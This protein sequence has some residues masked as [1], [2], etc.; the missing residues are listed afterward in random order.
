MKH[1][2]RIAVDRKIGVTA[3]GAHRSGGK[4]TTMMT[5]SSGDGKKD[6][7]IVKSKRGGY[8]GPP[9][10]FQPPPER[11]QIGNRMFR[12]EL[13]EARK[14]LKEETK[15]VRDKQAAVEAAH[16]AQIREKLRN[17]ERGVK[18]IKDNTWR[19]VKKRREEAKLKVELV[20]DQEEIDIGRN[21]S[22]GSAEAVA[23]GGALSVGD[24]GDS[25]RT[26]SGSVAIATGMMIDDSCSLSGADL[27]DAHTGF[28]RSNAVREPRPE[29]EQGAVR[30]DS[31]LFGQV[32]ELWGFVNTF[33]EPLNLRSVPS[34]QAMMTALRVL[35]PCHKALTHRTRNALHSHFYV[36]SGRV[37]MSP[38]EARSML[39]K[40][41]VAMAESLLK[42]YNRLFK[43]EEAEP[44]LGSCR[45]PVNAL[46]WKEIAR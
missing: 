3:S 40:L 35:N 7:V 8:R 1:A 32:L 24:A 42:D 41:G 10:P 34:L 11:I 6:G 39:D 4:G 31:G 2:S 33:T 30:I 20:C 22:R 14:K 17:L 12:V 16:R 37:D 19:L 28:S 46:T 13:I 23:G 36:S 25:V 26:R 29:P 38:E 45:V 5:G 18:N 9:K 21:L 15:E 44:Q 27:A 43:L